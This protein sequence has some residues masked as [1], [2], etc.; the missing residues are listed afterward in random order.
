MRKVDEIAEIYDVK[1]CLGAGSYGRVYL[2]LDKRTAGADFKVVKSLLK[3]GGQIPS[4]EM[5]SEF[6]VLKR[7]DHPN[8][9]RVFEAVQ[10]KESIYLVMEPVMGGDLKDVI[11]KEK[12]SKT[13]IIFHLCTNFY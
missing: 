6:E 10:D 12:N 5:F 11:R 9:I 8:I 2:A 7:L 3:R 1:Q 4:E 13:Q